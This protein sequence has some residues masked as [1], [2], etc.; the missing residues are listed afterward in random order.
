MISRQPEAGRAE[1]RRS[2]GF[3]CWRRTCHP[4]AVKHKNKSRS[5]CRA[6]KQEHSP[7][8]GEIKNKAKG[9]AGR[10]SPAAQSAGAN[11]PSMRSISRAFAPESKR[12]DAGK[13][14]RGAADAEALALCFGCGRKSPEL[15][16]KTQDEAKPSFSL[17]IELLKA[18]FFSLYYRARNC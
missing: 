9:C 7:G 18:I 11:T 14:I 6:A 16:F 1:G 3:V 17:S 5:R 15:P 12:S 4:D 8:G 13:K 2:I 10:L